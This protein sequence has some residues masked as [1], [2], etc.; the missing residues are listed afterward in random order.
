MINSTSFNNFA[1]NLC[2]NAYYRDSKIDGLRI[3]LEARSIEAIS[4][5]MPRFLTE[6]S[7]IENFMNSD[8]KGR[9]EHKDFA[10]IK[11]VNDRNK[12]IQ[13][14]AFTHSQRFTIIF[15]LVSYGE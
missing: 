14:Q 7:V 4:K 13:F 9:F 10:V 1:S 8:A 2:I 3:L 12:E 6:I 11:Q 5:H 15:R